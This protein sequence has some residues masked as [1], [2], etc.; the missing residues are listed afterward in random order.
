MY[1]GPY[2]PYISMNHRHYSELPHS[3]SMDIILGYNLITFN[4]KYY[5]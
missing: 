4:Y 3:I 5:K 1:K 2:R